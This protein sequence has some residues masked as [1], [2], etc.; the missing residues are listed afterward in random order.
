MEEG[1][2]KD[3]RHKNKSQE[4]P[5]QMCTCPTPAGETWQCEE[6]Q[7]DVMTNE[8]FEESKGPRQAVTTAIRCA[9]Q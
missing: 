8:V 3:E 4:R 9:A 7:R 5:A 6:L 1:Q 2:A